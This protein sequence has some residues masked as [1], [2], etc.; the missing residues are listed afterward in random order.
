MAIGDTP[1]AISV[2]LKTSDMNTAV[3]K[4]TA[5]W[6]RF[7]PNQRIRYDFLDERFALMYADVQRMGR[8]FTSFAI[9]AII[10]ACLGLFALS[11]FLAEQRSKE[12]SI[13]KVLGASV[14]TIFR[15]LTQ[16]FL[17]LVFIALLIAVPLGWY[18]MKKWLE[19]YEYRI[20]IGWEAFAFAGILAIFIAVLTI[21]YQAI[22]AALDNPVKAL[23]QE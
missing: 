10:V 14:P 15:M 5:T 16:N 7:S 23:G 13:R 3:N 19:D 12:M 11:A 17:T 8:I 6:D 1:A 21:S 4:L 18:L 22:R 9:L 2:K 20:D